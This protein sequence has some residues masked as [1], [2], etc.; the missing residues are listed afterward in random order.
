MLLSND[1]LLKR[2]E[3]IIRSAFELFCENGVDNTTVEAISKKANVGTA[4]VYRYFGTKTELAIKA[5]EILWSELVNEITFPILNNS[6]YYKK[7]GYEQLK[8]LFDSFIILYEYHSDYIQFMNDFELYMFSRKNSFSR[9]WYSNALLAVNDAFVSAL[10]K[11]LEDNSLK[12]ECDSENLYL[13]IWGLMRGFIS[14][15]VMSDKVY[16]EINP[17][18]K[19]QFKIAC[20]IILRGLKNNLNGVVYS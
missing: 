9:E 18:G 11:G 14:K 15:M 17:W 10:N 4:S 2:K 19:H 3:C 8:I 6:D 7:S 20:D 12:F 13:T 16:K 5:I 1:E